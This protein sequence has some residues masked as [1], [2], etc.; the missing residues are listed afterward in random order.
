MVTFQFKDIKG[1]LFNKDF[2]EWLAM[3]IFNHQ[4]PMPML[5]QWPKSMWKVCNGLP[6]SLTVVKRRRRGRGPEF[7][8]AEVAGAQIWSLEQ[9]LTHLA[10]SLEQ[11]ASFCSTNSKL[12]SSTQIQVGSSSSSRFW[13]RSSKI[14]IILE[15]IAGLIEG[16][17]RLGVWSWCRC[18]AS[19]FWG[20]AYCVQRS[21]RW[22]SKLKIDHINILLIFN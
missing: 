10:R 15:P 2:K 4:G 16:L 1:W 3:R 6:V 20:Q 14:S 22:C 7:A 5:M 18:R 8:A 12:R 19:V 9:I 21:V 13:R 11:V 17:V